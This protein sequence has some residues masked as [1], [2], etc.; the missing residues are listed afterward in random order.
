M[1]RQTFA[2]VWDALEDGAAEAADMRARSEIMIALRTKIECWNVNQTEA[3]RRLGVT[4]PR[5]N[6]LMR[7]RLDKFRLDALINL[8]QPAGLSVR[9]RAPRNRRRGVIRRLSFPAS[10]G[11]RRCSLWRPVSGPHRGA[12]GQRRARQR[13]CCH[14]ARC[15]FFSFLTR[16]F[17]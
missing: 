7:G 12:I 3:A 9:L 17:W 15:S 13:N 1:E 16:C 10:L 8:A 4:Q 2:S 14:A 6:D 5:L 11:F